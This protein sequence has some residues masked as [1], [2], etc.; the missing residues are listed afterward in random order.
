MHTKHAAW[1]DNDHVWV[2]KRQK[3]KA[4]AGQSLNGQQVLG[5]KPSCDYPKDNVFHAGEGEGV[6][7]H[8]V[9]ANHED[10]LCVL[11]YSA[12]LGLAH[13]YQNVQPHTP[14]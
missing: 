10:H 2:S 12:S 9:K 11:W 13:S 6:Y 14:M 4:D 5:T 7:C 1:F 8:M 3:K